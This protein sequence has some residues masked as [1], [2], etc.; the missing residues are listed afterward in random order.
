LVIDVSPV[1]NGFDN[2]SVVFSTERR[3]QTFEQLINNTPPTEIAED[4]G[5]SRPT[6][7][8]YIND[9]RSHDWI[10][11]NGRTYNATPQGKAVYQLVE[12]L[13]NAD[14][15]YQQVQEFLRDHPEAVPTE[16][17]EEITD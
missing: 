2:Q 13:D 4:L 5:V 15:G 8:P 6:I 10:T 16:V 12:A 14:Q 9:F 1:A 17:I 3:L 11:K 7:Q